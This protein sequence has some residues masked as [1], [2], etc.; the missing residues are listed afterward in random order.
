M[1][2]P[3]AAARRPLTPKRRA[4]TRRSAAAADLAPDTFY[5]D[6]V[7]NLRNGVL[8]DEQFKNLRARNTYEAQ[9]EGFLAA[10]RGERELPVREE[11]TLNVQRILNAAYR[12]AEEACEVD[13][14]D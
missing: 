12:S 10:V 9:M 13:V 3:S 1:S 5:K 8:A 14:E 7:W 11:E 6:L 4:A 2:K